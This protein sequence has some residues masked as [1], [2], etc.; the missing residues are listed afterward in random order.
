[1]HNTVQSATCRSVGNEINTIFSRNLKKSRK[2]RMEYLFVNICRMFR[3]MKMLVICTSEH[4][5]NRLMFCSILLCLIFHSDQQREKC[6][7]III[8]IQQKRQ[9]SMRLSFVVVFYSFKFK[10]T[11]SR[12]RPFCNIFL[13]YSNFFFFFLFAWFVFSK[14][15][16]FHFSPLLFMLLTFINA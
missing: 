15:I 10:Y 7:K 14:L 16:K 11:E 9:F 8:E 12:K 4:Q 5:M 2:F 6:T 13:F 3:F 1:M